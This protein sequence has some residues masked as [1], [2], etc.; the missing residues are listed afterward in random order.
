MTVPTTNAESDFLSIAYLPGSRS[1]A[2]DDPFPTNL[3]LFAD[4]RRPMI[5]KAGRVLDY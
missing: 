2:R 4:E 1:I 5:V 3:L